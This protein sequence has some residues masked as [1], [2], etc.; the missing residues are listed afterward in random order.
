M[1]CPPW[2]RPPPSPPSSP[3][4]VPE[5]DQHVRPPRS[6]PS[7]RLRFGSYHLPRTLLS[8]KLQYGQLTFRLF[9]IASEKI[10]R[11]SRRHRNYRASRCYNHAIT[12][13]L[14]RGFRANSFLSMNISG[15]TF[16]PWVHVRARG[17]KSVRN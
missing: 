4:G 12:A 6:K 17:S 11:S 5:L 14:E 8:R 15:D 13:E 10:G 1:L 7:V 3:S 9:R 16:N 2:L